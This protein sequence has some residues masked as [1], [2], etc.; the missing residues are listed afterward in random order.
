MET[1]GRGCSQAHQL[2]QSDLGCSNPT[3]V[4]SNPTRVERREAGA[5]EPVRGR[6]AWLGVYTTEPKQTG[7]P[8]ARRTALAKARFRS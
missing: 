5:V 4:E 1:D 3:W 2:Q 7:A 6:R 8:L